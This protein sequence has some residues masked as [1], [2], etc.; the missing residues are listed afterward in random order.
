MDKKKQTNLLIVQKQDSEKEGGH[1][2]MTKSNRNMKVT[3]TR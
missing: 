3:A 1:I 2:F